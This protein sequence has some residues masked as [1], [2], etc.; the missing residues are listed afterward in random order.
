MHRIYC[1]SNIFRRL[2]EEHPYFDVEL[3]KV[4]SDL[5]NVLLFIYSD[6]HLDDLKESIDKGKTN[7]DL[8]IIE[9]YCK[10]NYFSYD[11]TSKTE[12][13]QIFLASP[14]EAY[15][16]KDYK[17]AKKIASEEFK[18]EDLYSDLSNSP[19]GILL[20]SLL[21]SIFD[22]PINL[23]GQTLDLSSLD[24]KSR[25]F[26]Q[27]LNPNYSESMTLG[28][29]INDT[30][31][32]TSKLL[33]DKAEFTEIRRFCI[34]YLESNDFSFKTH[35]FEFDSL[36]QNSHL[37]KSFSGI[38]DSTIIESKKNDEQY[39]FTYAYIL[40]ETLGIVQERTSKNKL[41]KST[42][43][44][45]HRDALH[46]FYASYCDYLVTDDK[47]LQVKAY[48]LYHLFGIKTQIFSSQDFI[49][50][51]TLWLGNEETYSLLTKSL[52]YDLSHAFQIFENTSLNDGYKLKEYKTSHSFFN[53][54]NRIQIVSNQAP[55]YA[56]YCRREAGRNFYLYREIEL[57]LNKLLK[58]FGI[59]Q[60]NKGPLEKKEFENL[61][62]NEVIRNWF[63]DDF[64]FELG[65]SS[66]KSGNFIV[67]SWEML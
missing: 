21:K 52:A 61:A 37:N 43:D 5:K 67:L 19:E 34:A 41:K 28:E 30:K 25:D 22:L 48:I 39:K 49:N 27:K 66:T 29:F 36:L 31:S 57:I 26:Y 44:S 11:Y 9:E 33:Y 3:L 50:N 51:R 24:Q 20:N 38:L 46:C 13:L 54:F 10:D 40:L 55:I 23:F 60:S 7:R 42:F 17:T 6:A 56:L 14:L 64:K 47:G 1:D 4:S 35:G 16:N 62:N 2:K 59:D 32:Y 45:M 65:T 8:Q 63:I 15:Y 18:V 53:Y 58:I 12:G